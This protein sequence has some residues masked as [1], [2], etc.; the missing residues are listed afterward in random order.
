M[1][2]VQLELETQGDFLHL[3]VIQE[4]PLV[5]DNP[6]QQEVV[7]EQQPLDQILTVEMEQEAHLIL[8]EEKQVVV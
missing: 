1:H 3:K 8:Q 2:Q 6:T 7:V 4:D 5:M